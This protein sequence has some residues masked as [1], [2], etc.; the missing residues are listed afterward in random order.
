MLKPPFNVRRFAS[1]SSAPDEHKAGVNCRF[2]TCPQLSEC[3][4]SDYTSGYFLFAVFFPLTLRSTY[5]IM[6]KVYEDYSFF[7]RFFGATVFGD[8]PCT[9]A[10]L[11]R[12]LFAQVRNWLNERRRYKLLAWQRMRMM[13]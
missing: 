9:R 12:G 3:F 7:T 10:F 6:R 8:Y 4:C 5:F 11:H 1:K 13:F 2:I